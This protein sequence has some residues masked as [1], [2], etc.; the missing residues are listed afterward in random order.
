MTQISNYRA[1]HVLISSFTVKV[2]K[3]SKIQ[4]QL[5][6]DTYIRCISTLN[7][8][9]E[10]HQSIIEENLNLKK[11]IETLVQEVKTLQQDIDQQKSNIVENGN[12]DS[13]NPQLEEQISQLEA[14]L[15]EKENKIRLLEEEHANFQDVFNVG[16]G[17]SFFFFFY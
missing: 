5:K 15:S 14:V 9:D 11:Q 8:V 6:Y 16:K 10:H 7:S 12:V 1:P 13:I 3:I 4:S 2:W 17:I